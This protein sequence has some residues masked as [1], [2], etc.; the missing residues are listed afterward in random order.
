MHIFEKV[1]VNIFKL[2]QHLNCRGLDFW[3]KSLL[4]LSFFQ[5]LGASNNKKNT[6]DLSTWYFNPFNQTLTAQSLFF[7]K[8]VFF[9]RGRIK[10]EVC[11]K[12]Y[13]LRKSFLSGTKECTT[14]L[15]FFDKCK[16]IF[17]LLIN[18]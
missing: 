5:I 12:F 13:C 2:A 17:S 14:F 9:V 15:T 6:N 1:R 18:F 8:I 3:K 4:V 16:M 10:V 11:R 7:C